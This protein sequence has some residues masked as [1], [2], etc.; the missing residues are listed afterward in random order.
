MIVYL[1]LVLISFHLVSESKPARQK[2]L[3]ERDVIIES[4]SELSDLVA[5]SGTLFALKPGWKL[6]QNGT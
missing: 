2:V 1:V 4:A 5:R 3:L 6:F